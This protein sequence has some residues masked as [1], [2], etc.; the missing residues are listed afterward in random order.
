MTILATNRD[1][2]AF[3]EQPQ[4]ASLQFES[5]V[6]HVERRRAHA[7]RHY[8]GAAD[9]YGSFMAALPTVDVVSFDIFDT[10]LVR[11]VDHPVDV[12]F[13]LERMPVFARHRFQRPVSKLRMEAEAK[14]RDL[15]CG[16]LGTMEV[17]LLEIY[18]VFCDLNGLSRELAPGF[19]AAEEEVELRLCIALPAL[20]EIYFA[21]AAAGKRVIFVSD[22]YHTQEFVLRLLRNIGYPVVDADVFVSS[23][24][25][26]AK[27]SGDL[28]PDVIAALG[29]AP[30][31]ILHFGD[32]PVSDFE[33]AG[34]MGMQAILH[35]HKASNDR[36]DLLQ[37]NAGP[38]VPGDDARLAQHSQLRGM[39]RLTGHAAERRGHGNDFWW[40]F[41]YSA[42]G[43]LTVGFCQWLEQSLRAE[44]MEHAY[45]L[46]RDGRLLFDIYQALY[47]NNSAACPATTLDSSRRAMLVPALELAP[48]FAI[49]S[50][51]GGIG[52]RPVREYLE[53]LGIDADPFKAEA[54]AAGFESLEEEVEGCVESERLVKFM[55]QMP[56]LLALLDHSKRERETLMAYLEEQRVTHRAR[57]ALVDVGWG[58]TI[59]KSLHVL[60]GKTS[61]ATKLT[62]FYLATFPE[63]PHSVLPGV[64]VRS[65]LAHRGEPVPVYDIIVSFLNLFELLYTSAEGSLLHFAVDE[66][67][68]GIVTAVRQ[69]SDKSAEQIAHLHAM[70]AGA[71]AF[72]EDFQRVNAGCDFPALSAEMASEEFFRVINQPSREEASQLGG[73]VHCDNLGSS[74][75][76]T[77]ARLRPTD[78]PEQLLEDYKQAHW[79]QGLLSLPTP[80]AAALRT[81]LWII[82]SSR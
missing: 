54:L 45:F 26:K 71:L 78:D 55:I 11:L 39:I 27:G 41:G 77:C 8:T 43:P 25:R 7:R 15:V 59:H 80:E 66:Q 9:L 76:H 34:E 29:V 6:E 82:E 16:I 70:H 20:Q 32:H 61:P 37:G 50:L 68:S 49:P 2:A 5:L 46:M 69:A 1:G 13:H 81:L 57:V 18:Q 47:G 10:A 40:K 36:A 17:N 65:Y 72:A 63:A 42:G 28:F 3:E 31:R 24:A 14:A 48:A 52:A 38:R 51:L 22:I 79:K 21:A 23:A 44:G 30:G 67:E 64:Q 73:L 60:L 19:M 4:P 56:V 58:G 74:S 75:T 53:R 33:R 35:S 62:G 12:F